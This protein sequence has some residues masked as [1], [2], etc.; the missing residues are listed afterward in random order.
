MVNVKLFFSSFPTAA[1]GFMCE[2]G[3]VRLVSGGS[4]YE[5]RVEVCVSNKYTTAC[6]DD[7]WGVEEATV[8]C[9]QLGFTEGDG[10]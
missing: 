9:R 6:D 4:R 10:C 7:N 1:E 3:A 2:D 8:V 5:G